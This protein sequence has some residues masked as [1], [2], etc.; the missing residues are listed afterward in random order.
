MKLKVCTP[1]YSGITKQ[2]HNC[3]V[4]LRESGVDVFWATSQ[5]TYIGRARNSLII[6]GMSAVSHPEIAGDYS[7]FLHLDSDIAFSPADVARLLAHS[8]PIVSGAYRARTRSDRLTA[9][10]WG[11]GG[12]GDTDEYLPASSTGLRKVDWC[13][14]GFLLVEREVFER[15]ENPW[16]CHLLNRASIAGVDYNLESGEDQGFCIKA[17]Q[18]GYDVLVDCDCKVQHITDRK[19][20]LMGENGGVPQMV[21]PQRPT[22]NIDEIVNGIQRNMRVMGG[23]VD[24]LNDCILSLM[25]QNAED[26]ETIKK[27]REENA[28]LKK[29]S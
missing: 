29:E 5:S 25:K 20:Y 19:E 18:A 10:L 3:M 22:V 16:F 14:A 26:Q 15:L 28:K 24:R 27:L 9:G 2:T 12:V 4:N 13:G 21:P 23:E 11:A 1:Y 6:G 8:A 17:S 7:H